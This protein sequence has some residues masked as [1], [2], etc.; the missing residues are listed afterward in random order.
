[1]GNDH[2]QRMQ[3]S[4]NGAVQEA[5][6]RVLMATEPVSLGSLCHEFRYKRGFLVQALRRDPRITESR[7]GHK[8]YF[9]GPLVRKR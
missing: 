2:L 3:A 7:K 8:V 6:S 5:V 4:V 1:M 9:S